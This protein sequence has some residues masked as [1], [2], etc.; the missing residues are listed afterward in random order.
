M[1]VA[2]H[3]CGHTHHFID[4]ITA[5]IHLHPQPLDF[6]CQLINLFEIHLLLVVEVGILLLKL[7]LQNGH[8]FAVDIGD[9]LSLELG[10]QL[11]DFSLV[12]RQLGH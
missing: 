12:R 2:L 4:L 5:A 8:L 1:V 6:I 7:S 11:T 10:P 9:L 3:L